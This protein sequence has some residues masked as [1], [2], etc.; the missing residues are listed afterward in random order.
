MHIIGQILAGLSR[1]R[2]PPGLSRTRVM[3]GA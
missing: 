1:L 2:R 3:L